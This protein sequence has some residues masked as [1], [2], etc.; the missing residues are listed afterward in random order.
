MP[1]WVRA[2]ALEGAQIEAGEEV[3]RLARPR[4]ET[5]LHYAVHACSAFLLQLHERG[6]EEHV[7]A[8]GPALR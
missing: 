8:P 7:G 1:A 5:A 4:P 2:A 6:E 3:R